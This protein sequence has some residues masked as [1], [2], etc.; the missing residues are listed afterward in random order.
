[1][2]FLRHDFTPTQREKILRLAEERIC[3]RVQAGCENSIEE[4]LISFETGNLTL[5]EGI[6]EDQYVGKKMD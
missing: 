6:E 1:M 5:K 4:S 3:L 2:R